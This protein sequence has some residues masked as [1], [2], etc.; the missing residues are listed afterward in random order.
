[1]PPSSDILSMSD[2]R[3]LEPHGGQSRE[4]MAASQ[5]FSTESFSVEVTPDPSTED[6]HTAENSDSDSES[7]VVDS[8]DGE[9]SD[10]SV[11]VWSSSDEEYMDEE[12]NFCLRASSIL[13]AHR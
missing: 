12:E 5:S 1:M 6:S 3:S 9:S 10:E 8:D 11:I 7:D 4:G 13:T 2:T